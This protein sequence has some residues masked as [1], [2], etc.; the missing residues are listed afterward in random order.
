MEIVKRENIEEIAYKKIFKKESH[1]DHPVVNDGSGTLRWQSDPTVQ[2]L[3]D[4]MNL[5]D[6]WI[7]FHHMGLTKNSEEVRKLYRDM[8]YS[9]SGYWN[10]FYWEMNNEDADQYRPG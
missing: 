10:V 9:L 3:V 2:N 6:I 4:R 5:N 8:G 7:L 1:H